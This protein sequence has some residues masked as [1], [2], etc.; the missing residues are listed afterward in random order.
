MH[1][2]L[3]IPR[4]ACTCSSIS[5]ITRASKKEGSKNSIFYTRIVRPLTCRVLLRT[6][7]FSG[8]ELVSSCLEKQVTSC[9]NTWLS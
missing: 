3:I 4:L 8:R 6:Q 7:H 5:M 9:P 1:V 2:D